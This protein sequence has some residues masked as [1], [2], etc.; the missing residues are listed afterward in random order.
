MWLALCLGFFQIVNLD[1]ELF[2][3]L[4]NSWHSKTLVSAG[5]SKC[6]NFNSF[7]DV[8]LRKKPLAA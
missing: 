1:L 5:F 3:C 6:L 7:P 2:L 4:P 8:E